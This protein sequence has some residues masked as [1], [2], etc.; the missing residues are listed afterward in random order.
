[1]TF[2]ISSLPFFGFIIFQCRRNRDTCRFYI[3]QGSSFNTPF[4]LYIK[5]FAVCGVI[6]HSIR[7]LGLI[8]IRSPEIR[9][10]MIFTKPYT[11]SLCIS[12][13]YYQQENAICPCLSSIIKQIPF[14]WLILKKENKM[15][16]H[17]SQK[18]MNW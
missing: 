14:H 9:G 17:H 4:N 8:N 10:I 1:M 5:R 11:N 12:W 3:P 15:N 7:I 6:Q 2:S 13:R 18:Y 16:T